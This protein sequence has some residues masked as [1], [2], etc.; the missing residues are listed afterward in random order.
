MY[1]NDVTVL[2][3]QGRL[4]Q[5]EYAMEAVKQ[6]AAA[7]GVSS[8]THVVLAAIKRTPGELATY[9]KKLI[10]ID[11]HIGVALA[12]LTSDARVLGKYMQAQALASRMNMNRPIPVQRLVTDI[13]DKA[14]QNTQGYGGRPFGVGLLVAGWD[15]ETGAH[16]YEFS[17]SGAFYEYHAMAI[18][19]RSQ[20]A[21][22]YLEKDVSSY[23]DAPID[24]LIGHALRALRDTLPPDAPA[25]S[26]HNT[27]IGWLGAGLPFRI[28]EDEAEVQQL[29]DRLPPLP[30]RATM[31][32]DE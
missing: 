13:S 12:G 3:P 9:Q 16:L 4:F 14:Q 28:V 23:R 7:V 30:Q 26:G 10:M 18:G 20:S 19:A 22:T 29:L 15:A 5:V 6:G 24:D 11:D 8:Q 21:R 25:L 17:P 2:S 32:V 27:A 1:D 31:Q